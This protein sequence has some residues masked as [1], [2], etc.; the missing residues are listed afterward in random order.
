MLDIIIKNGTIVNHDKTIKADICISDEKISE[1]C[2]GGCNKSAKRVIDAKGLYVLPGVID[3]HVHIK[4]P[5]KG[6]FSG[7]DFYTATVSAAHGGTTT[8]MDFAIQWDK[9]K[10][11]KETLKKRKDEFA[12]NAVIDY[13]FH[14]CST[15]STAENVSDMADIIQDG[16]PSFKLYMTY[17]K[18]GRMSDDGVIFNVLEQTGKYGGILGV[19]AENDSMISFNEE[20]FVGQGKTDAKYFPIAKNNIVESEAINRVLYMN[21]YAGGNLYIFHLSTK[22]GLELVEEAKAK[23]QSVTAETCVH[24][25]VLDSSFYD[26]EDGCNFICSPPLRSKEDS[27]ALWQ[28]IQDGVITTISSDHCGF[29]LENKKTGGGEFHKTPNGLPG[30]ELLLPLVYTKG[31]RTGKISI[32]K[33]VEILSANTAKTFG[34]FPRKG[35]IEVGS[36]ADIILVD[37]EQNKLVTRDILHS[38]IDWSPYEGMELAGFPLITISR[39]EVIVDDGDFLGQKGRGMFINRH[40]NR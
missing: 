29:T 4:H 20:L 6:G 18:Q 12:G 25:L 23:G 9:Q 26:R 36:D 13:A 3:P 40:I 2:E 33:M 24:Y 28:G 14:I 37:P 16:T 11:L 32:N 27:D 10:T 30:M 5:F 38:P 8:L 15:K 31:V 22:E 21:K 7:D 1:I 39:G 35:T 19:H 34:M 17:S